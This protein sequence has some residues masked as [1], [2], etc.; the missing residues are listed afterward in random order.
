MGVERREK[1]TFDV[2][3]TVTNCE[4]ENI[5]R[6]IKWLVDNKYEYGT[7]D[8]NETLVVQGLIKLREATTLDALISYMLSEG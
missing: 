1:V 5:S 3:V 8:D 2:V 7:W 4:T 6:V